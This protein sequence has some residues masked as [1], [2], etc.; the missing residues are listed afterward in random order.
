MSRMAEWRSCRDISILL[1][2]K[3]VVRDG[4]GVGLSAYMICTST[5]CLILV[6]AR[7]VVGVLTSA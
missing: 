7:Q 6:T 5:I 1:G 3:G 4:E 2:V